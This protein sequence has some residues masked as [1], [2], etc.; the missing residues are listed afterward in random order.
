MR[1][2][3]I[4]E[5]DPKPQ[6]LPLNYKYPVSSWIYK[7]FAAADKDFA[8]QLHHV[9]YRTEEGKQLKLF[10]FSDIQV[11]RGQ[12]KIVGDRMKIWSDTVT[13]ILSFQLPEQLQH[14]ITG[15]F[16]NQQLTIGDEI[17]QLHA[18]VRQVEAISQTMVPGETYRFKTLSPLFMAKKVENQPHPKYI[19]PTDPDYRLLFSKNLIDKYHA[20][21]LQS[22]TKAK[23]FTTDDINLTLL[24]K[25]PK[26]V[27]QTIKA[28]TKEETKIQ[29]F[30]FHFELSGP[31]ELIEIGLNAGFGAENAQGFGCCGLI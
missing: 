5:I 24:T 25:E 29:A 7:V 16:T 22:E 20:H 10:T 11:P 2:K 21:C 9:G 12:W 1:I 3:L 15:I 6:L 30:R 27:L 28:F 8:T 19:A 13:L 26:S 18:K 17:S 23:P 31:F 14:F 4:L